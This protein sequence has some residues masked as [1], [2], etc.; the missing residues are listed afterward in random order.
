MKRM[1][2]KS[3]DLKKQD[4]YSSEKIELPYNVKDFQTLISPT[5]RNIVALER[6]W[7]LLRHRL[8]YKIN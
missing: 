2:G 7:R 3:I 8:D 1:Q 4:C 6:Q 5:F